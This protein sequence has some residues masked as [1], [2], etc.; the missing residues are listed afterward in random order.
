MADLLLANDMW[1]YWKENIIL[2]TPSMFL[3][4]EAA[5]IT[6]TLQ[7]IVGFSREQRMDCGLVESVHKG[8][9][10]STRESL[11]TNRSK[12]L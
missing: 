10:Q 4:H 11:W 8:L 1:I 2:P 6:V 12:C 5:V 3:F 7:C 9:K